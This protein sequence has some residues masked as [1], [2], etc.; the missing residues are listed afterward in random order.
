MQA[1]HNPLLEKR[2]SRKAAVLS[3]VALLFILL[4]GWT[5]LAHSTMSR[6]W[7]FQSLPDYFDIVPDTVCLA[8]VTYCYIDIASLLLLILD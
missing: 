4:I 1:Y 8:P 3:A 6:H 5:F 7:Q 2:T